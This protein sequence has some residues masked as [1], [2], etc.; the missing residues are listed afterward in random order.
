MILDESAADIVEGVLRENHVSCESCA[1]WSTDGFF[2]ETKEK[3]KARRAEGCRVVDMECA[4]LAACAAYR[5][6]VFAQ[7]LFTADTLHDLS[8][9]QRAWGKESR[10]KALLMGVKAAERL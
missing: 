8:H 4:A 7:I 5:G 1:T 9:E 3:V 10:D 6:K 2:R